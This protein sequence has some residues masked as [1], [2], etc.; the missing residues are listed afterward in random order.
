MKKRFRRVIVSTSI[1]RENAT[2]INIL[3]MYI[4]FKVGTKVKD[5]NNEKTSIN[6]AS[7]KKTNNLIY[8]TENKIFHIK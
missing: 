6:V 3:Y 7:L 8:Q 1:S 5:K 4:P 2:I